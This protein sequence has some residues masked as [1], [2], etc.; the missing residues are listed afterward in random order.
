[1]A[2]HHNSSN[3]LSGQFGTWQRSATTTAALTAT[4]TGS[5]H[6]PHNT[7]RTFA[8]RPELRSG[9]PPVTQ[10]HPS[11]HTLNSRCDS[12]PSISRP[13]PVHPA[14][15]PPSLVSPV[16]S[17]L[18]RNPFIGPDITAN[19]ATPNGIGVTSSTLT[20]S[21][22]HSNATGGGTSLQSFAVP[23]RAGQ[24]SRSVSH[25]S[26]APP[27]HESING[28]CR[29]TKVNATGS[30]SHS[31]TVRVNNA[32]VVNVP[33]L[34]SCTSHSRKLSIG[35]I[36]S[37]SSVDSNGSSCNEKQALSSIPAPICTSVCIPVKNDPAPRELFSSRRRLSAGES[38]P[39]SSSEIGLKYA[40]HINGSSLNRASSALGSNPDE[41]KSTA[42]STQKTTIFI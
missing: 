5:L 26:A 40:H 34:V 32:C 4:T 10:M 15:L 27:Q 38:K 6:H 28:K 29:S 19:L 41:D 25:H 17:M 1:M 2:Q 13:F 36:H 37:G 39:E 20:R 21:N 22:P 33:D 12:L 23:G 14:L 35:P 9:R 16:S 31:V 30:N 8:S 24:T 42:A 7:F 3:N 11:T 18:L